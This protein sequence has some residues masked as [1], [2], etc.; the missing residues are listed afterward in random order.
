MKTTN[1]KGVID[2]IQPLNVVFHLPTT[3]A[4]T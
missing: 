1:L 4:F 2:N 3:I